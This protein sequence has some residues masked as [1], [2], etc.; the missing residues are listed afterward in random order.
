M[1]SDSNTSHDIQDNNKSHDIQ[2]IQD[3][4]TSHDI[5]DNNLEGAA[6]YVS[7]HS[8]EPLVNMEQNHTENGQGIK[9]KSQ[10]CENINPNLDT[11]SSATANSKQTVS[12]QLPSKP[13]VKA[14]PL[15]VSSLEK[16]TK[17]KSTTVPVKSKR[18]VKQLDFNNHATDGQPSE[19]VVFSNNVQEELVNEALL[20]LADLQLKNENHQK[21]KTNIAHILTRL[22]Q[23]SN[24]MRTSQRVIQSKAMLDDYSK[25]I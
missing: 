4:N 13:A 21:A 22:D 17:S 9:S 16:D 24:K 10:S 20:D 12:L 6:A 7:D 14:T 18:K 5:Q 19:I 3:N 15:Y 23:E 25:N 8:S 11:I 1:S 2:D